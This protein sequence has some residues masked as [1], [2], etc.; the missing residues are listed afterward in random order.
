MHR[1]RLTRRS[2]TLGT[3]LTLTSGFVNRSVSA[4]SAL[5]ATPTWQQLAPDATGPVAR[6]D[7]TL[8]ADDTAKQ[9]IIFGGRDANFAALGDT[10]LFD[11][12]AR[13]WSQIEG[14]APSSRF[15]HAVAVDQQSRRLYL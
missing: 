11:L 14:D 7:H 1:S 12:D 5:A 9:L 2:F 4:G 8:A 3:A 6:W 15:G 10:W 13:T